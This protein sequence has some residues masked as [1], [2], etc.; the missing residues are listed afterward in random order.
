MMRGWLLTE[1]PQK[2][3]LTNRPWRIC[4]VVFFCYK[5]FQNT[6]YLKRV[7][8]NKLKRSNQHLLNDCCEVSIEIRFLLFKTIRKQQPYI[9]PRQF[10]IPA[11]VI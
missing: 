10:V 6:E 1:K 9:V 3:T 4:Q 2:A 11:A 5:T 7:L 8:L